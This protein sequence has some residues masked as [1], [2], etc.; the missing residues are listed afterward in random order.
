M[1]FGNRSFVSKSGSSLSFCPKF[2]DVWVECGSLE[3][4]LWKQNDLL[5]VSAGPVL[6]C[7]GGIKLSGPQCLSVDKWIK[8]MID[9]LSLSPISV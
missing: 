1:G 5:S 4:V 2:Q 6:S 7:T 8:K 9:F 3:H